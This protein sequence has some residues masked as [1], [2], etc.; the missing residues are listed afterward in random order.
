MPRYEGLLMPLRDIHKPGPTWV[1]RTVSAVAI[2][3]LLP[4]LTADF[5]QRYLRGSPPRWTTRQIIVG[6]LPE[7][8][9]YESQALRIALPA[10]SRSARFIAHYGG[11]LDIATGKRCWFGIRPREQSE[12]YALSR[13]WQGLFS[14][15]P[16]GLLHSP[17]WFDTDSGVD[18]EASAAADA[19]F[20]SPRSKWQRIVLRWSILMQAFSAQK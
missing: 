9:Q 8:A 11:L 18:Q 14:G 4:L 5:I 3:V 7:S 17:A 10:R 1:G 2:V 6:H 13:D 20:S 19:Y 16:V 15:A 12:W